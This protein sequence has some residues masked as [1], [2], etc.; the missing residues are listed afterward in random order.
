LTGTSIDGSAGS[1]TTATTATNATNVAITDNTSSSATWYPVISANSSGNNPATT[2]STKLSFVPNTGVLSAT[3]FSGAGTGL[4]GTASSLSI[5]GNAATATSATTATTATNVTGGAAG[6]LV[7]Q[8][9]A[10]TT[11]T[12][13]LGTSGYVLTAGATV[14]TYVAQ[15]TLSVG[16]ATNATN[17]TNVNITA[18]STGAT[19][20]LTFV[21]ATSGNLP[22]LVNSSITVNAA[23]GTITGGITGGT[24]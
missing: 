17:A 24:F 2:S 19:N 21:T 14:P 11:S 22:Q 5:G 12:L 13:A 9:A 15:S 3:S 1:A 8:T 20:Y 10:A 4:T 18:A 7:Y 6:S 16:S 23:N